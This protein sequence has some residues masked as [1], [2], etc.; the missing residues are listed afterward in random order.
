MFALLFICI[1][2]I[3]IIVCSCIRKIWNFIYLWD[4]IKDTYFEAAQAFVKT[5]QCWYAWK[6]WDTCTKETS[7]AFIIY[8]VNI[9]DDFVLSNT[10]LRLKF[11]SIET[12]L[13]KKVADF[14]IDLIFIGITITQYR[15]Y[16][17]REGMWG[18]CLHYEFG[19]KRMYALPIYI[20]QNFFLSFYWHWIKNSQPLFILYVLL[21]FSAHILKRISSLLFSFPQFH[22]YNSDRYRKIS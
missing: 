4:K 10:R 12:S 13:W 8:V 9:K 16:R 21:L 5:I 17:Q 14:S 20:Y 19:T 2:T 6:W 22:S 11:L 3:T 18:C 15:H 1:S 7:D